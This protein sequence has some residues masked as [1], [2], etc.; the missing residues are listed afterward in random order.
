MQTIITDNGFKNINDKDKLL[1]DRMNYYKQF[2]HELEVLN[3]RKIQII[4]SFRDN[5]ADI[6]KQLRR[7]K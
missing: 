7:L 5:V 6:D 3:Y 4:T 1:L 2:R